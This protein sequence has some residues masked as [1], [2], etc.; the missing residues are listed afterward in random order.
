LSVYDV[1]IELPF[2]YAHEHGPVDVLGLLGLGRRSSPSILRGDSRE[3]GRHWWNVLTV[4]G[5]NDG[6]GQLWYDGTCPC[7]GAKWDENPS[8]SFNPHHDF[9]KPNLSA[10]R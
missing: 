9:N 10:R 5:M 6:T 7:S 4:G 1:G 2:G 3:R 8:W